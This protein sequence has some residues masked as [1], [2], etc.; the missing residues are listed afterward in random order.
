MK[1]KTSRIDMKEYEKNAQRDFIPESYLYRN[2][3][4]IIRY[5]F[6]VLSEQL[7]K[8]LESA[9][10]INKQLYISKE[11]FVQSYSD[12]LYKELNDKKT[13][14]SEEEIIRTTEIIEYNINS[15]KEGLENVIKKVNAFIT[16]GKYIV[17]TL[18][19]DSM[20]EMLRLTVLLQY[21]HLVESCKYNK[22]GINCNSIL[23]SS[24]Y[25]GF[26][27]EPFMDLVSNLNN[28]EGK[29]DDYTCCFMDDQKYTYCKYFKYYQKTTHQSPEFV[30]KDNI[31][32]ELNKVGK[33]NTKILIADPYTNIDDKNIV[34]RFGG[35]DNINR[36]MLRDVTEKARSI[37]LNDYEGLKYFDRVKLRIT[38]GKNHAYNINIYDVIP[39]TAFFLFD[40]KEFDVNN[41]LCKKQRKNVYSNI[42]EG[43]LKNGRKRQIRRTLNRK[44]EHN[45]GIFRQEK[46]RTQTRKYKYGK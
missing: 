30:G 35:L 23:L 37:S 32:N 8:C 39:L 14:L 20:E 3:E 34:I 6:D 12:N 44:E 15:N 24:L 36:T 7:T 38:A 21:L 11:K 19:N 18:G 46:F 28:Y 45:R 16:L 42:T 40:C 26:S 2:R 27:L 43:K 41:Y 29:S 9:R 17:D 5:D 13:A 1:I 10:N 33:C 22:I 25:N 4:P 31:T